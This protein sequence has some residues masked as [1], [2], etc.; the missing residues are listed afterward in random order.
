MESS[1]KLVA[2]QASLDDKLLLE[3]ADETLNP[4]LE[5]LASQA[6]ALQRL[7]CSGLCG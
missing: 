3:M 7:R 6:Q 4:L 1:L 5:R 2:T